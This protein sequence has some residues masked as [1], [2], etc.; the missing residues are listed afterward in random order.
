MPRKAKTTKVKQLV[1]PEPTET[2]TVTK[3]APQPKVGEPTLG[4]DP[5]LVTR[6]GL[7]NLKVVES[8]RQYEGSPMD[9]LNRILPKVD[10]ELVQRRL[11]GSKT[12]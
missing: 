5:D 11:Y 1:K 2:A 4:V 3:Y 12:G 8:G 10:R 7:G 6:V 9:K